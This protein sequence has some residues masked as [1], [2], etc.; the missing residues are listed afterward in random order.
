MRN[1]P[2]ATHPLP[3]G[4]SPVTQRQLTC[5]PNGNSPVAPNGNSRVNGH[6]LTCGERVSCRR[7]TDIEH[8]FFSTAL[9]S[10]AWIC[11]YDF[12]HTLASSCAASRREEVCVG[13]VVL[14]AKARFQTLRTTA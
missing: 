6:Q 11:S 13:S 5:R 14:E 7:S 3:N 8:R 4:N 1:H 12:Q 2:T 9:K 10:S